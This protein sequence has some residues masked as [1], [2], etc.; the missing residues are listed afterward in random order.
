MKI[1]KNQ[2]VA[3]GTRPVRRGERPVAPEKRPVFPVR[4]I[5]ISRFAGSIEALIEQ[6]KRHPD[7]REDVVT[8]IRHEIVSREYH[9]SAEAVAE[10][11]LKEI[12]E[13]CRIEGIPGE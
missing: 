10:A 13:T 12:G 1:W 11:L 8:R 7:C 4:D 6:I 2:R 3:K 9:L 5:V